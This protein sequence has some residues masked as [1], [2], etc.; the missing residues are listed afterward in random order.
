V[1]TIL[2]TT[3][4]RYL[5]TDES[6]DAM[7]TIC[8]WSGVAGRRGE[9]IAQRGLNVAGPN[10]RRQMA[11]RVDVTHC[12]NRAVTA[13]CATLSSKVGMPRIL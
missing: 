8:L 4:L 2:R 10:L 6:G 7:P 12:Y 3:V 1:S 13:R 9:L 11:K 5:A